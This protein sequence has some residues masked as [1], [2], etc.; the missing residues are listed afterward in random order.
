[1]RDWIKPALGRFLD[2][3]LLRSAL[4]ATERQAILDLPARAMR[5]DVDHDFVHVGDKVTHACLVVDGLIA[6]FA[7]IS[8]GERSI[9]ALHIPGEMADLH[10]VVAPNVTWA[11]HAMTPSTIVQIPH[12]AL[13]DLTVRFPAIAVAFWRDCVTD[14]NV[15][16]QWTVNLARKDATARVAHL[17][18][19]MLTRYSTMG[20]AQQQSYAF[21]ITQTNLADA[22]GLTQVHLNRTL[23]RIKE[24]GLAIKQP[25]RVIIH[26]LAGLAALAEFD[27]AYL[28]LVGDRAPS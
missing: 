3:L 27:P 9:V 18:C 15:L 1:M 19:E 26:D 2:R 21:A 5:A 14:A 23:K 16:A 28:Q 4:G 13:R 25:D 12:A 6:R 7:Q 17:L 20:L 24:A 22:L 11:L 8:S 10:S